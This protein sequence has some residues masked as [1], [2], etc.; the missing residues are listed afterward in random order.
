MEAADT[1]PQDPGEEKEEKQVQRPYHAPELIMVG[2]IQSIVQCGGALGD[3][4]MQGGFC[5][6]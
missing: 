4:A 6:S 1:H 2:Q 5:A 3:D